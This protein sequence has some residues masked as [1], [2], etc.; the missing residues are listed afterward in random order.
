MYRVIHIYTGPVLGNYMRP[1][2]GTLMRP[3]V[4]IKYFLLRS[5]NSEGAYDIS[6]G[7]AVTQLAHPLDSP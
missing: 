4:Q 3:L 7:W 2:Q 1:G 5:F 6:T